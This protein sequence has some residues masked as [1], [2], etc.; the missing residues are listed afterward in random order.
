MLKGM[1]FTYQSSSPTFNSNGSARKLGKIGSAG[2]DSE[3]Q[4]QEEK[5]DKI[6]EVNECRIGGGSSRE[7]APACMRQQR[8]DSLSMANTR[9]RA[10]TTRFI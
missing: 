2:R 7:G 9:K 3:D 4:Q 10:A 6:K 8:G 1:N 5:K